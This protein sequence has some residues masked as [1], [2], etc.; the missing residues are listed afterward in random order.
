MTPDHYAK[1]AKLLLENDTLKHAL[2]TLRAE[3]L[4]A[5]ALCDVEAK[6]TILRLQMTVQVIDGIRS[7][8]ESAVLR[9]AT[10]NSTGTFA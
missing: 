6:T 9:T 5:L 10:A 1:E 4:E 7:E 2:D 8:L 3:A